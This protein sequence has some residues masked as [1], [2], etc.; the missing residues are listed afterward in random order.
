MLER[1]ALDTNGLYGN[2]CSFYAEHM[3]LC[4]REKH[5]RQLTPI[6]LTTLVDEDIWNL[7]SSDLTYICGDTTKQA[8]V[9]TS[10]EVKKQTCPELF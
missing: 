1:K 4:A 2:S 10:E 5:W 3:L 6:D 8:E 9:V 7:V